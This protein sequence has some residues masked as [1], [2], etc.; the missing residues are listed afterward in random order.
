MCNDNWR[1][2]TGDVVYALS[3]GEDRTISSNTD[4]EGSDVFNT[5]NNSLLV[6]VSTTREDVSPIV[7]I[8][9]LGLLMVKNSISKTIDILQN[10][11]ETQ[12]FGGALSSSMKYI[13]RRTDLKLAANVLRATVEAVTPSDI[14]LRMYAKVLY[15]GDLNFDGENYVEMTKIMGSNSVSKNSFNEFV[16]ELDSTSNAKNFVSFATKIII[17]SNSSDTSTIKI[18]FYPEIRNLTIVSSLR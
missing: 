15:E 12:S 7:D 13:T 8:R 18:D 3:T 5:E 11:S 10:E 1:T 16:F 17:T 14:E 6:T 4:I 9:K 2:T